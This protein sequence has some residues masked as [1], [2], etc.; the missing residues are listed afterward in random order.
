M[1][2]YIIHC[3]NREGAYC[4]MFWRGKSE[5]SVLRQFRYQCRWHTLIKVEKT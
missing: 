4:Q 2:N 5:S 3:T 1:N